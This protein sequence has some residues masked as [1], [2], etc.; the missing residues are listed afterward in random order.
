[1]LQRIISITIG[2]EKMI[3]KKATHNDFYPDVYEKRYSP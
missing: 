1:M 3:M 2:R